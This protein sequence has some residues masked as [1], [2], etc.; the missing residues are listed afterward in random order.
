MLSRRAVIL[1]LGAHE[2]AGDGPVLFIGDHDDRGDQ[3]HR[4]E[5]QPADPIDLDVFELGEN[6]L[7]Q[8]SHPLGVEH[9]WL[10][11]EVVPAPR[12]RRQREVAEAEGVLAD[13]LKRLLPDCGRA[14]RGARGGHRCSFRIG[15]ENRARSRP[16]CVTGRLAGQG[17]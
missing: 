7:R 16:V 15:A 3:R 8:H 6:Q 5:L 14:F 9:G 13:E 11:V 12:A 10:H 1:H 17:R 2:E 4:T